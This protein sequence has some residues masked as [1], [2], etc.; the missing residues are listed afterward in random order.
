MRFLLMS[1]RMGLDAEDTVNNDRLDIHMMRTMRKRTKYKF[2][3]FQLAAGQL[4]YIGRKRERERDGTHE[5]NTRVPIKS[6]HN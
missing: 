2:G 6:E 1:D 3:C 4:H 5:F